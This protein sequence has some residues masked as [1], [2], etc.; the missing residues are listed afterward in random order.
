MIRI[1]ELEERMAQSAGIESTDFDGQ[2]TAFDYD[3]AAAEL[4]RLRRELASV[5]ATRQSF[6]FPIYDKGA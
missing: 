6:R 2:R 5:S 1:T 4:T 3:A